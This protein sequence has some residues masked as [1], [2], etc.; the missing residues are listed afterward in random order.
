MSMKM[1]PSN[2]VIVVLVTGFVLVSNPLEALALGTCQVFVGDA[3]D[4][5]IP[6]RV[7]PGFGLN[8][9][10]IPTG[11]S[12][13]KAW[14][15]DPSRIVLGFDGQLCQSEGQNQNCT[16]E[17]ATVV[18]LRQIKPIHFPSL[19][20]HRTGNTLLTIITEGNGRNLYQF[21]VIPAT[22]NPDCTTFTINP[23]SL[24]PTPLIEASRAGTREIN[25]LDSSIPQEDSEVQ[26][27]PEGDNFQ[28]PL[29]TAKNPED[30]FQQQMLNRVTVAIPETTA[31]SEVVSQEPSSPSILNSEPPDSGV[32]LNPKQTS[33]SPFSTP[34][35]HSIKTANDIASGLIVAQRQGQINYGTWMYRK[36]QSAIR[37]LRRG[38]TPEEA[39][40]RSQVPLSVFTQLIEWGK[41]RP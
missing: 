38:Q 37:L 32:S 27:A 30:D 1:L 41:N 21:T 4:R 9:N 6:V 17:G 12:V 2:R 24:R 14:I 5:R 3:R 8:L 18:H 23:D 25:R 26:Y 13:K 34:L 39:A 29:T 35:S 19:P 40:R 22:G 31:P 7:Y 36:V 20:R 28:L 10:F 11:E 16:S 15:D 33:I